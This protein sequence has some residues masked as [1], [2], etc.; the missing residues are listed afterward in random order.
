MAT[1][2]ARKG[3]SNANHLA[4]GASQNHWTTPLPPSQELGLRHCPDA[5]ERNEFV[6]LW[7]PLGRSPSPVSEQAELVQVSPKAQKAVSCLIAA[8]R[9]EPVVKPVSGTAVVTVCACSKDMGCS[10]QPRL[11]LLCP[12]ISP[13]RDT[14]P[15]PSCNDSCTHHMCKGTLTL[16]WIFL[17]LKTCRL[18]V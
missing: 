3:T 5:N 13:Q 12:V 15:T 18:N 6:I 17:T 2:K 10:T 11:C 8:P 1:N 14:S 4:L 16:T 9:K 7:D